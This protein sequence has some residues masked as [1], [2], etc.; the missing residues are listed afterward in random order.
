[1]ASFGLLLAF[2]WCAM[3]CQLDVLPLLVTLSVMGL[4][5]GVRPLAQRDGPRHWLAAVGV[6]LA[7]VSIVNSTLVALSVNSA[8]FAIIRLLSAGP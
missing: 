6:L 1:L 7:I 2:S 3:R 8:R 5:Q 4:W